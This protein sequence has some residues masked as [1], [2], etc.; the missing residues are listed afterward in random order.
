MNIVGFLAI[1][2]F[3]LRLGEF[4]RPLLL[5]R[6][7]QIAFSTGIATIAVERVLDSLVATAILVFGFA[8]APIGNLRI[9]GVRMEVHMMA[10]A[11]GAA[12]CATTALLIFA[13]KHQDA[14]IR[15][16]K[17]TLGFFP[18][19]FVSKMAGPAENF[20]RGFHALPSWKGFTR[21]SAESLGVWL[22]RVLREHK[23]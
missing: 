23:A 12:L 8:V 14:A 16:L 18:P 5:R 21:L 1:T 6:R 13:V 17:K 10:Y 15:F 9:P 4:I 3:P 11:A 19:S 20:F 7:E 22:V 2:L